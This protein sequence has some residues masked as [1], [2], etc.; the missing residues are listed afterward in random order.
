MS[1][2]I[3]SMTSPFFD[4][5]YHPLLQ[6][7]KEQIGGNYTEYFFVL[8]GVKNSSKLIRNK[9]PLKHDENF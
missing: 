5:L 3:I 9:K 7:F 2:K 8:K 4:G 1:S 6:D